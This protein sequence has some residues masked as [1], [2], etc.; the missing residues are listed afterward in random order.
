MVLAF[1]VMAIKFQCSLVHA[2]KFH[3][4]S[5]SQDIVLKAIWQSLVELRTERIVI[6]LGQTHYFLKLVDV[7]KDAVIVIHLE[8]A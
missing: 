3:G 2:L 5:F 7:V 1:P 8:H 4:L 6:P